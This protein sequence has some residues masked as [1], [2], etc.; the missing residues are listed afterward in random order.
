LREVFI[1]EASDEGKVNP[2]VSQKATCVSGPAASSG[3]SW[4][5]CECMLAGV[6]VAL[7]RPGST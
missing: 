1:P 4:L 5:M 2:G 7:A 3:R 6:A